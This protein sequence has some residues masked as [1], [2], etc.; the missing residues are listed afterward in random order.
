MATTPTHAP[1]G[2]RI[3]ALAGS[4]PAAAPRRGGI[5]A[6]VMIVAYGGFVAVLPLVLYHEPRP[7]WA[8]DRPVA[9]FILFS[10][11]GA[12]ALIG[13]MTRRRSLL[14]AAGVVCLLQ[15]YVSFSLVTLGFMVPAIRL[16]TLGGGERWPA[17]VSETRR[18]L[19]VAI[20]VVGLTLGA[21]LATLG[22]T[23]EVCWS[24]T[25]GPDGGVTYERI[26]MSNV[27]TVPPGSLAG[28]CD[29]GSLTPEGMGIGGLLAIGA[30]ALAATSARGLRD[31][32]E[33]A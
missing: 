3:G 33:P 22:L 10:V 15:S 27:M 30:I 14:V 21:W 26:P 17:A 29:G 25:R 5:F 23:E 32:I 1:D 6:A 13:A 24:A 16:L 9:L 8:I 18:S 12:F 20:V 4:S 11:P 2:R 31:N 19:T 7:P 28:G